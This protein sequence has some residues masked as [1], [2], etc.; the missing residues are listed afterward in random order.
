MKE[1]K[2]NN[3]LW[4]V[5]ALLLVY[6]LVNIL[7]R[8][9]SFTQIAYPGFYRQFYPLFSAV[10]G[11]VPFSVG[12]ILYLVI[13]IAILKN[14]VVF[15]RSL[16]KREPNWRRLNK[17]VLCVGIMYVFFHFA[18]AFNYYKK[19]IK[20]ESIQQNIKEDD[21]KRVAD[22]LLLTTQQLSKEVQRT[23]L[24]TLSFYKEDFNRRIKDSL[25]GIRTMELPYRYFPKT[26]KKISNYSA[27]FSYMGISGYYNP[28]TAEAQIIRH[29]P[30]VWLPFT[31]AHEQAHQ[32]GYGFESEANFVGYLT[33]VQSR[34]KEL[35]YSANYQALK[36][37]LNAIYPSDSVYVRQK[38]EQY[39]QEMKAD[40][41][42]ELRY[43][44]KYSGK[45]DELFSRMNDSYLKANNQSEGIK[46]Y[47]NF[48]NLLV[49]YHLNR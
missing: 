27:I 34:D 32:M 15:I 45:I 4:G 30:K 41:K 40:R 31:M 6:G 11:R 2:F 35:M 17:I 18:W 48:V 43:Y 21:L 47:N 13:G 10:V 20:E 8:M 39:T 14:I 44:K 3:K 1:I 36:Y 12:D 26:K 9:P 42:E 5:P 29:I 33:C 23:P 7:V 25:Q 22:D 28:F 16:W 24:G 19:P 37:V 49:D 38:V 46:S